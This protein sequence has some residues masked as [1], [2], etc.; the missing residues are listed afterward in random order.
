MDMLADHLTGTDTG[1]STSLDSAVAIAS[2]M[3]RG[4]GGRVQQVAQ[5]LIEKH[6]E[7]AVALSISGGQAQVARDII[8]GGRLR[9]DPANVNLSLEKDARAEV[10]DDILGNITTESTAG[11]ILPIAAAADAL[12]AK[13]KL[14]SGALEDEDCLLYTSP[15]PRDRTRSRMPSSA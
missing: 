9:R 6:P 3:N 11:I 14:V 5:G 2:A 1:A 8:E 7:L 12:Y 13:K 15:S 10:L 4:L